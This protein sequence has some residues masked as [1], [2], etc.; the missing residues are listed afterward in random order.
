VSTLAQL[1]E[2][3]VNGMTSTR[4][5]LLAWVHGCGMAALD[6]VL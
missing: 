5:N 2:P 4:A 1:V 3:L 6:A